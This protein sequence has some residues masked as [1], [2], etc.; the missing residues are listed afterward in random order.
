MKQDDICYGLD[1]WELLE[2]DVGSA[3]ERVL[4]DACEKVGEGFD[5]VADR[6]EWPIRI[7]AFKRR[8]IGGDA[9]A[10]S[11][12]LD[13]LGRAL[14]SLD[15]EHCDPDGAASTPTVAMTAAALALGR[16]IVA[17]YVSWTCE[18]NGEVIEYTREQVKREEEGG[19]GGRM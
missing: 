10:V 15:E 16:A 3:L 18:P 8:D 11:L 12:G 2:M 7:L 13:A 17:E 4:E 5:A 9:F 14:E 6:I 1:H 19:D